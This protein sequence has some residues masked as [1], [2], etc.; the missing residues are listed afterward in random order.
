MRCSKCGREMPDDS[1][2]C[3]ECG[4]KQTA[5]QKKK[6]KKVKR[7]ANCGCLLSDDSSFCPECGKCVGT[8]APHVKMKPKEN[9][10]YQEITKIP[11]TPEEEAKLKK[12]NKVI[13]ICAGAV[14]GL[15]VVI[16]I[17]SAVIKPSS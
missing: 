2:F 9:R 12:R 4:E 3:P 11:R 8:E 16:A 13:A 5:G 10:I 17:L 1:L 14:L 6:E 7:C 15:C